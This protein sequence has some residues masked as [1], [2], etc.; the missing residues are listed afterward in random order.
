M[1]RKV[2]LK[3]LLKKKTA[4]IVGIVFLLIATLECSLGYLFFK[5]E[6]DNPVN[7]LEVQEEDIYG[8]IDVGLMTECFATYDAGEYTEKVYFVWD[9]DMNMYIADIDDETLKDM[10]ALLKY[11]YDENEEFPGAVTIKGTSTLIPNDLK[12]IAIDSYN[13]MYGEKFLNYDNFADYLGSY[14]LDV[15]VSPLNDNMPVLLV[16]FV[17][18]GVLGLIMIIGFFLNQKRSKK[19]MEK[20]ALDLEK[21]ESELNK[22]T[23]IFYKKQKLYLTDN[24]IVSYTG[25]LQI[26]AYK[27]VVCLYPRVFNYRGSITK[28]IYVVTNDKKRYVVCSVSINRKTKLIFDDIYQKLLEKMPDVLNEKEYNAKEKEMKKANKKG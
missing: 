13:E 27:E 26:I 4:L 12:K 21:I 7:F 20:Y 24:Y 25:C 22:E 6:A 9:E 16:F 5:K 14:Y 15:N 1:E 10:D 11:S 19:V 3:S 18:F 8:K 2:E 17:F 28:Y 23:A